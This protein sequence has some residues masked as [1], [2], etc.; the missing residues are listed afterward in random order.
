MIE[1]RTVICLA[2]SEVQKKRDH[3]LKVCLQK[4]LKIH[5]EKMSDSS[6][7]EKLLIIKL[8]INFL[9]VC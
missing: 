6:L 2:A 7:L 9:K 1:N 8:V 3:F 4:L 5:I